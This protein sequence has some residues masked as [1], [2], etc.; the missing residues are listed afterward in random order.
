VPRIVII[1]CAALLGCAARP[2]SLPNGE[3]GGAEWV[4]TEIRGRP[5]LARPQVTLSFEDTTFGGYGGCNWMGGRYAAGGDTLRAGE[6][7]QTMRACGD[8]APMSQEVD[9]VRALGEVRRY[10]AAGDTLVLSGASG[11]PLLR[12]AARRL[13]ATDPAA[14]L[15]AWRLVDDDGRAPIAGTRPNVSFS[16]DSLRGHGGCRG[17][18]GSYHADGNR[19]SVTSI[20]MGE[21]ECSR[22]HLL[23]QED[24]FTSGLSESSHF[25]VTG[26]T[27]RL[28]RVGGAVLRLV[29]DSI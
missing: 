5:A 23:A 25:Q 6:V 20:A 4:L 29:R 21:T 13:A 9:L 22:P 8:P 28:L 1:A 27:L 11:E 12:F 14:L 2:D 7:T 15:G 10:R 24:G 18:S 17:F 26:D 19:L 16:A 3:M